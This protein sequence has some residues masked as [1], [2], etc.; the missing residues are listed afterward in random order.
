VRLDGLLEVALYHDVA[1]EGAM[2]D[3]YGEALGLPRVAEWPDGAA[4]RLGGLVVL[5]FARERLAERE[6]PIAEH[7]TVGPGHVCFTAPDGEYEAW[8][9]RIGA[10]V[11]IIHEHEWKGGRRSFYFRDPAANLLEVADGDLWPQAP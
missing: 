3:F 7:G 5:L 10:T 9:D 6:G 2:A 8:K 4:H 1:E 11:E